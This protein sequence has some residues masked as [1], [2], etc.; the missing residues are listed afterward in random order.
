[1]GSLGGFG[2]NRRIIHDSMKHFRG[3]TFA[4]RGRRWLVLDREFD[5]RERSWRYL[6]VEK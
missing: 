1:M 2:S 6:V 4:A 3:S 5:R